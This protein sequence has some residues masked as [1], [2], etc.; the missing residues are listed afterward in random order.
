MRAEE[1]TAMKQEETDDL[2]AKA[3]ARQKTEFGLL[4]IKERDGWLKKIREVEGERDE[5]KKAAG[6]KST[7]LGGSIMALDHVIKERDDLRAPLANIRIFVEEQSFDDALFGMAPGIEEAYIQQELR[8]LH[9]VVK[10]GKYEK[11]AHLE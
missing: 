1:G 10:T 6:V 3:L 9:R 4:V 5:W 11:P 8:R 2:V 7:V